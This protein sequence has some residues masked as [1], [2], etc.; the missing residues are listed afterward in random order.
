MTVEADFTGC[1]IITSHKFCYLFRVSSKWRDMK[2][3]QRPLIVELQGDIAG[4]IGQIAEF[5]S[6]LSYN[7]FHYKN[8]TE[9][10]TRC[11]HYYT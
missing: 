4:S 1:E 8:S 9:S 5:T 6:V 3:I 11:F 7:L 2:D 10:F